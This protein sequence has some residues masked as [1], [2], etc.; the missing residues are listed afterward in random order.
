[1]IGQYPEKLIDKVI[2]YLIIININIIIFF[3]TIII[4][5]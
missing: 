5:K 3:I 2:R 4:L 1:M